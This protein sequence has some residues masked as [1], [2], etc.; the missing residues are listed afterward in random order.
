MQRIQQQQTMERINASETEAKGKY[1]D[2]D[3]AFRAFQQAASA[4]P[5][6]IQRMT[7]ASDPAEFAYKT[8]KVAIDL[9]KVGSMDELLKSERA[10]WEA[11]LK[12]AIPAQPQSFPATTAT[13]GS[14]GGRTGPAWAGA[15]PIDQLLAR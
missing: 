11:E 7:A 15:V 8:G 2:Y 14:V 9:E 1:A 10:K 3:D 13:D 4:N 5:S 6:L 12:A